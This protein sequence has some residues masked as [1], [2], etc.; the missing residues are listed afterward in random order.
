M[1]SASRIVD[2]R[3]AIT[4]VVRPCIRRAIA[5]WISTSVA[6][7]TELVAAAR[8]DHGDDAGAKGGGGAAQQR[9]HGGATAPGPA[10]VIVMS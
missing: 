5:R 3:C 9:I 7:S 1:V 8:E 10:G 2:R 6:V 4:N